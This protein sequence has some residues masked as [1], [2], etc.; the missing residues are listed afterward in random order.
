MHLHLLLFL[1]GRKNKYKKKEFCPRSPPAS[2]HIYIHVYYS[3][4]FRACHT[5]RH[6]STFHT[7]LVHIYEIHICRDLVHLDSSEALQVSLPTPGL[8]SKYP[9]C[10]VSV[11]VCVYTHIHSHTLPTPVKIEKSSTPQRLFSAYSGCLT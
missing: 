9:I 8:T 6:L 1:F 3:A 7:G 2:Q 11:C 5:S 10:A 4:P